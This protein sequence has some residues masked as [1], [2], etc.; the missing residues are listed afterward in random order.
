MVVAYVKC[1]EEHWPGSGVLIAVVGMVTS[2]AFGNLDIRNT[3]LVNCGRKALDEMELKLGVSLRKRDVEGSELRDSAGWF[4]KL[5]IGWWLPDK[6]QRK[7]TSHH[8]WFRTIYLATG[9]AFL[10]AAIFAYCGYHW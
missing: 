1:R 7:L 5:S 9:L 8:F 2:I 3:E 4:W 10:G 6:M